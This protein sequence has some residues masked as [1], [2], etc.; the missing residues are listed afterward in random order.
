[1]R[2]FSWAKHP[3]RRPYLP[4]GASRDGIVPIAAL[5]TFADRL[6]AG[7]PRVG[8]FLIRADDVQQSAVI[9]MSIEQA[10]QLR[11]QL[12]QRIEYLEQRPDPNQLQLLPI[13]KGTNP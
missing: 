8:V 1:M 9:E 13:S 10:R 12:T 6:V 3:T 5:P 7:R 11:D 2:F 4:A